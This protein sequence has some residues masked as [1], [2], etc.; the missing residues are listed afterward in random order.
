MAFLI[1]KYAINP[2]IIND[3][4][5]AIQWNSNPKQANT[6]NVGKS[7]AQQIKNVYKAISDFLFNLISFI[8]SY[9]SQIT[10]YIRSKFF[11]FS[12]T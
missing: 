3:I 12:F 5:R 1:H 7:K 2:S 10:L 11:P 9:I 4:K 6:T 8:Y